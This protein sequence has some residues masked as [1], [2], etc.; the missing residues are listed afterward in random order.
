MEYFD[1]NT[2][3]LEEKKKVKTSSDIFGRDLDKAP[4]DT[5]IEFPDYGVSKAK[6][7]KIAH[8]NVKK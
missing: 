4:K 6:S 3:Y 8:I 5:K 2:K 1:E 7:E